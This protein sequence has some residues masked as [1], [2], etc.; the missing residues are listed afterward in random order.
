M[1]LGTVATDRAAEARAILDAHWQPGGWT[2]PNPARYP[3]QWLW[4]SCFHAVAWAALGEPGR[5]V[6][7]LDSALGA[8][9]RAGFVP[10]IRYH[11]DPGPHPDFWGRPATSS[12]TQPP[13]YG[14]AVATMLR[15]GVAV[16]ER[17]TWRAR[18]GLGF[19]L[20][21]RQRDPSGLVTLV[22]PWESG[23]DDSPRWDHWSPDG[24]HRDVW[25]QTKG[26][27][28][29]SVERGP[30]GEPLANPAFPVASAGF[31]ALVAFN[32]RE[33]A[34]VIGDERL[35]G[36]AE[37]L[38][39]ALDGRWDGHLRTWRDAGPHAETSG[40][41]RTADSLLPALVTARP[42]AREVALDLLVELDAFGAPFG[43]TGVHREEP[44]FD[45]KGYWRG[46]SWPQITYLLWG[47][48]VDA[49]RA[50]V[51]SALAQSALAG[52]R[53]S[54]HAEHWDPD[55]G[56]GLGA[57]PQSWTALALLLHH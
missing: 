50:D 30:G 10:H 20:D 2:P 56:T 34:G 1:W 7:E 6:A 28:L 38:V 3:W 55:D 13:M 41:I 19:L 52:A 21:H 33:L 18:R 24:F 51:A 4:D 31:N 37:E 5:A 9:D 46:S 39:R 57:I 25:W 45:P 48:A 14:H 42:A 22:H 16:P 53:R 35:S 26:D 12:I 43:P 8:Q 44:V 49:G 47:A 36:H 11:D 54:G 29:T 40:R 15:A 27:L 23:A 32:A 17:V